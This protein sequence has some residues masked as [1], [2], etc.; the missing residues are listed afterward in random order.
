VNKLV[1][2]ETTVSEQYAAQLLGYEPKERSEMADRCFLLADDYWN[3]KQGLVA[4][5]NECIGL[6]SSV[7]GT[8]G[9]IASDRPTS[10]DSDAAQRQRRTAFTVLCAKPTNSFSRPRWKSAAH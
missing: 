2:S 3:S 6:I 8:D 1:L 10:E 4:H 9:R 7:E 5:F